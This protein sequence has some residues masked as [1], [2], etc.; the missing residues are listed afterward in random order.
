M[1]SNARNFYLLLIICAAV[2]IIPII[3]RANY[4][5]GYPVGG[6]A[7]D[8][9]RNA[10]YVYENKRL[11]DADDY[12]YGGRIFI[13]EYG[14][15]LTAGISPKIMSR[16]LPLILGIISFILFYLILK[17]TDKEISGIASLFLLLSPTFIYLFSVPLKYTMAV[18][19]LLLGI[20]LHLKGKIKHSI[21]ILG[22]IGFFS[23]LTL[24]IVAVIYLFYTNKTKKWEDMLYLTLFVVITFILQ[25]YKLLFLGSP[26]SYFSIGEKSFSLII[27]KLFS[28]FGSK[29]G[30]SIFTVIVGL[31]GVYKKWREKYKFI[32]V[33]ALITLIA[34]VAAYFEFLI[35]YLAF[36][37]AVFAAYGFKALLDH[38]W[39]S[40][41]LRHLIILVIVCGAIFSSVS[42]MKSIPDFEPSKGIM[43]GI[44]YLREQGGNEIVFSHHSRGRYISY[45]RRTNFIDDN[46]LY[47]RNVNQRFRDSDKILHARNI[48]TATSII[49]KNNIGYIWL[50][51]KLIEQLWGKTE[52]EL[53]FLLRYSPDNFQ[54]VFDNGEVEI[55]KYLKT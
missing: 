19:L 46:T 32:A 29:F 27:N 36:I 16:W 20:Y 14:W 47:A 25:F 8:S 21:F 43:E 15:P 6:E 13:E 54:K 23:F 1:L 34:V 49:N 2:L 7:Y 44:A 5:L 11:P 51:K 24:I 31:L 17:H 33:Y 41:V 38:N 10:E 50:D 48:S 28:D 40:L 39:R 55:Y 3:L 52:T 22:I 30:L 42:Y 45:A 53:I 18:F 26:E 35:F 37:I 12:S 4:N 9:L